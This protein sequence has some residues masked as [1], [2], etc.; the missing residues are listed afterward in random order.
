MVLTVMLFPILFAL[1]RGV[2]KTGPTGFLPQAGPVDGFRITG[3]GLVFA[4]PRVS[5]SRAPPA[6][7]AFSAHQPNPLGWHF[8]G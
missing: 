1:P 2:P 3:V 7:L 5:L 6:S 4:V 8:G